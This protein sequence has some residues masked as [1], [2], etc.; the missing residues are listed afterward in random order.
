[1]SPCSMGKTLWSLGECEKHAVSCFL[2]TNGC[3]FS[4]SDVLRGI[5]QYISARGRVDRL[6]QGGSHS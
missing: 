2:V 6:S 1:V 4:R 5:R 3:V